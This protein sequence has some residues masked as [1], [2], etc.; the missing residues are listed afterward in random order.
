MSITSWERVSRRGR[1][2]SLP[3]A[4]IAQDKE[5]EVGYRPA[6]VMI[7]KAR[8]NR[9]PGRLSGLISTNSLSEVQPLSRYHGML[10][11]NGDLHV[12][13]GDGPQGIRYVHKSSYD[14]RVP[15]T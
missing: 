5:W 6:I 9:T 10:V 12:F 14:L 4:N 15:R 3:R 7:E 8:E 1:S 11:A 13:G 2:G